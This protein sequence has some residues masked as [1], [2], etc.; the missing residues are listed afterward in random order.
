MQ[1]TSRESL[2]AGQDRLETLL[3]Q[4]SRSGRA[5]LGDALLDVTG[6]LDSNGSAAPCL[7]RPLREGADKAALICGC[8]DGQVSA[9]PS[10]WWRH[11]PVT[12]VPVPD[13]ADATERPPVSSILAAAQAQDRLDAVEDELFRFG[14]TVYE[15][16][17]AAPSPHRPHRRGGRK[18]ALVDD[19]LSGKVTDETLRLA[20]QAVL[21]P[22]GAHLDAILEEYGRLA[23]RAPEAAGAHVGRRQA[24]RRRQQDRL[25]AALSRTQ[26][27]P[28]HLESTSIPRSGAG[29]GRDR[30]RLDGTVSRRLDDA[31]RALA[32]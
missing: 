3:R 9:E 28:V 4:Q 13:V 6:L 30:R 26:G 22:R 31:G 32:G 5:A 29:S 27:H 11:C 24:A 12:L 1:G 17:G 7:T 25:A 2:R 8:L 10:T 23:V 16:P 14:R 20:R 15:C 18:A 21:A 19:L